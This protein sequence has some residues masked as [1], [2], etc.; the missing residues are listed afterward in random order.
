[1]LFEKQFY[2]FK[3]FKDGSS[4]AYSTFMGG[5]T[6]LTQVRTDVA[7]G[8]RLIIL[9]DSYG[10]ALPG[11]LMY[12]FEEIHVIDGRYFTHNMKDYVHEHQITD[13]LFANNI[14]QACGG[15]YRAY[16][17]FLT[18]AEGCRDNPSTAFYKNRA[19]D[20]VEVSADT[21]AVQKR[22]SLPS[23]S[24]AESSPEVSTDSVVSKEK[25]SSL[26]KHNKDSLA[27]E[28]SVAEPVDSLHIQ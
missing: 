13:I 2:T 20:T 6:K 16:E 10:N 25:H 27:D 23:V 28:A 11:Y 5:D 14:F 26:E 17:F 18:M 22:D 12:S 21:V 19:K 8:R 3:R 1:M 9:K 4:L 7:N 15:R 24:S